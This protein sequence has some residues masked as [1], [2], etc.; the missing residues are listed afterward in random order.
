IMVRT[1]FLVAVASVLFRILGGGQSRRAIVASRALMIAL[2][3]LTYSALCLPVRAHGRWYEARAVVPRAP[4]ALTQVICAIPELVA[5]LKRGEAYLM[6]DG[7]SSDTLTNQLAFFVNGR[8]LEGTVIPGLA[9][10]DE[11][12]QFE[13]R[14]NALTRVAECIFDSFTSVTLGS[15]NEVRQWFFIPIAPLENFL[16]AGQDSIRVDVQ[17][18]SE[19]ESHLYKSYRTD[20]ESVKIPFVS[21]YSWD[22]A[23]YGVERNGEVADPRVDSS[24]PCHKSDT[25]LNIRILAP[26]ET[27][28]RRIP[29]PAD[30]PAGDLQAAPGNG[31]SSG[32]HS[33]A[34]IQD[35]LQAIDRA[36]VCTRFTGNWQD[37]VHQL[38]LAVPGGVHPTLL[39]RVSGSYRCG[40]NIAG[41]AGSNSMSNGVKPGVELALISECDGRQFTYHAP[42]APRVLTKSASWRRFDVAAPVCVSAFPG[43]LKRIVLSCHPV[44]TAYKDLTRQ[45]DAASQSAVLFRDLRIDVTPIGAHPAAASY[46]IY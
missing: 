1:S 22:K 37:G 35:A 39:V 44:A 10:I 45:V 17:R 6:V 40:A 9:L 41:S 12:K 16:P 8:R 24:I 38:S 4:S 23:F 18:L 34:G 3:A 43:E 5:S 7:D 46:R 20:G 21:Y 36:T 31:S 13:R 30:T 25:G 15:N 33:A 42:W 2:A 27:P 26:A 28:A 29:P 32:E 11:Q 19:Q 14:D